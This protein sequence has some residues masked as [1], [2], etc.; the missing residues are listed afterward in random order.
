MRFPL[1]TFSL[2]EVNPGY[3]FPVPSSCDSCVKRQCMNSDKQGL[4][5][6]SYGVNYYVASNG[7]VI[8]GFIL[9]GYNSGGGA[10]KK[11]RGLNR[12]ILLQK[13]FYE[14]C[15]SEW[16]QLIERSIS[17]RAS[18]E[19][20]AKEFLFDE[21]V[22]NGLSGELREAIIKGLSFVH[23]YRQMNTQISQSVNI[24]I[25]KKYDGSTI[26][27]KLKTATD[28]ERAIY[29][30]SKLIDETLRVTKYLLYP[31]WVT[32]DSKVAEFRFHGLIFKYFKI[33]EHRC[34][35]EGIALR[36]RGESYTNI[37]A[38]SEAV[39]VVAQALLD[40]AVKY[41]PA[42][43]AFIEIYF[44]DHEDHVEMAV[45]SLGPR[46]SEH[47]KVNIFE[48]FKRGREAEKMQE[49]GAGFGLYI[50][51]LI[52]SRMGGDV[53]VSQSKNASQK[54]FY[55]T[56]FTVNIPLS[57]QRWGNLPKTR[58]APK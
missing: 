11:A 19:E 30:A 35:R 27:D 28:E 47:D 1:H 56:E 2:G 36:H 53:T 58:G 14:G 57:T 12:D 31:E 18:V 5:H 3:M 15:V 10:Y 50:S 34:K 45:K 32:D 44:C 54:G 40:N 25:E 13:K 41:S 6:C 49:E 48:P 9:A 22:R 8:F 52:L 7:S 51:S 4:S 20:R 39:G 42:C 46:L 23:D 55:E 37:V 16:E 26:E 38:N 33:Y 24:I 29:W 43:A 17:E 21:E